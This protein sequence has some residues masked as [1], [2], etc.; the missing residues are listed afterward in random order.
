MTQAGRYVSEPTPRASP[1]VVLTGGAYS[2]KT[3]LVQELARRG[4]PTLPEAAIQVIDSLTSRLGREDQ[5]RWRRANFAEFELEVT[6][7]QVLLEEEVLSSDVS[8]PVF[9]DRGRHDAVAYCRSRVVDV[10]SEIVESCRMVRYRSVFVLATLPGF[11]SR[12]ESGRFGDRE[13]S[14]RI[15]RIVT[16]VYKE[17]GYDPIAVRAMSVSERAEFVLSRVGTTS[18]PR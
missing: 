10:P 14:E 6:R 9:L 15:G 2:G 3:T 5:A 13:E 12:V 17:Y 18:P 4:W 11:Q 8:V 1:L 7:R 16:D